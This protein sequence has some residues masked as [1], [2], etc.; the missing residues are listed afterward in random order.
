MQFLQNAHQPINPR[1]IDV[2]EIFGGD[3][4]SDFGVAAVTVHEIDG[5]KADES[6]VRF[7]GETFGIACEAGFLL[8]EPLGVFKADVF[9][10]RGVEREKGEAMR[11]GSSV[12]LTIVL[13]GAFRIHRFNTIGFIAEGFAI[14]D[15][16]L[17]WSV[18]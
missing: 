2:D 8:S 5:L 15:T 10:S 4:I 18:R 7:G 13:C 12:T 17:T 11:A 14:H 1:L 3:K 6:E 16:A 9:E